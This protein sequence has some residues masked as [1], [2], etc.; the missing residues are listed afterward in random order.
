MDKPIVADNK[1]MKVELTKGQEYYFCSC[2]RSSNQPFCDG[3]HAGTGFK[4]KS[5]IAEE[6]GDCYLC[7]CKHTANA[8]F[9]DGS[10]KQFSAEQV[11]N[12]GPGVQIQVA[13]GSTSITAP[14]ATPT[15]E[16]PTV[17]FIH[18]L[19]REGLSKLGHH[20]PMTSMGVPRH[21]LPHWDDLQIMVAQ[22]AT[23][24]L[25]EDVPV[26]TELVIGPQ[27]QKPLKLSIPLFVSDMSFGSLS[28][29]A[30]TALAK[31]A[32]LAGTGICS[33]EGG[34]L[35]EEQAANS[36]YFYELASAQFGYDEELL[37]NVQAFHFKG[38][39]GA[40]TGTGGHLP[41]NKNTGKISQVRGIPEGEAAISP[42]TFKDLVTA[43]DFKRFADHVRSITGGIPI[44]FKL[45]ANH[46]EQD[47][48]FALDA[49]AD[50]I[51]L[52]GRGGGTGAAPEMFRDHISV[53]TIP[54]LARARRYLDQQGMSGKVTLII[55][56]GLRVPIDFVKAMALGA[57]GVAISNS[58]M[59]S[60]GCVAARMCNTNNCPAGIATQKADLRQRLNVEKSA[61]Q[62]HNFFA[63][64]VELMQVMARACGHHHLHGFN[65]N[66]LATWHR[67]MAH[68]SGVTYAGLD[69]KG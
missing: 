60:I 15:I 37:K 3:S 39:Q 68:L 58:A 23:K 52:D 44:G 45:S 69:N 12:E 11:G 62:L 14:A 56:G 6:T 4:P 55:T 16:E 64:S 9:C 19:A 47:I 33:G 57:D 27:A 53:P 28:E 65:P 41:S 13:T 36:R 17:A 63:A 26:G 42:P 46:I 5:F 34:M 59:Q 50:Y 38:G 35:P 32:E 30:K 25:L 66:D 29:E 48:Q 49:S 24:P 67:D 22:M 18:Q 21:L 2:G 31:G 1:P 43:D 20:G 10:H 8:P 61:K 7:Q 51:I 40:K 54:A